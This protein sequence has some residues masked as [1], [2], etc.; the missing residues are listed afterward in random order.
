M[1]TAATINGV[2]L[3]RLTG[4]VDAIVAEPAL[5]RFEFRVDN[6]WIDG[7]HSRSAIQ[8]FFGAGQEDASR[9]TPFRVDC[10]EPPILLGHNQAPNAG[11]FLLHALGACLTATLAYHAAA[12]GIVLERIECTI[13][14]AV[15]LRG[16]LGLDAAVRP[17]FQ[18]IRA[19]VTVAGDFG[20]RELAE[21]THLTHLSPVRDTITDPVPIAIT[22]ERG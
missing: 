6:G 22:V 5:A 18:Q 4:T 15:D 12:R 19:A 11:E 2:D 20:D 17:G 16:F 7:G 21:L 1:P 3:Q 13:D 8:G 14:G 10:D 9:T